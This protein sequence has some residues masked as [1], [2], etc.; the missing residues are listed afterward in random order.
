M[1]ECSRCHDVLVTRSEGSAPLCERC[2]TS[3][4]DGAL[5]GLSRWA[6]V[7]ICSSCLVVL[8][9]MLGSSGDRIISSEMSVPL[10]QESNFSLLTQAVSGEYPLGQY[11]IKPVPDKTQSPTAV[12]M[13]KSEAST[14]IDP[15]A[16]AE[17]TTAA[18][19][20]VIQPN[21]VSQTLPSAIT[22]SN[23]ASDFEETKRYAVYIIVE[24]DSLYAIAEKFLPN[25]AFLHEFT[26]L[27][28]QEND[29]ED[30]EA[31]PVG[32]ELKIPLDLKKED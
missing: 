29:L 19:T 3:N 32:M 25:G 31:L 26:K 10:S 8:V 16:P 6:F 12:S 30:F 4:G 9:S 20:L 21:E 24:G 14:Q 13:T 5:R 23:D 1:S 22:N 11:V 28:M 7:A 18:G 27:V 15:T 17:S 2:E